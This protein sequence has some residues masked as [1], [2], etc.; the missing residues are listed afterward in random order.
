MGVTAVSRATSIRSVV[1]ALLATATPTGVAAAEKVRG[2]DPLVI[3]QSSITRGLEGSTRSSNRPAPTTLRHALSV[4]DPP[5]GPV[6]ETGRSFF[7]SR[8]GLV[9]LAVLGAGVGYAAYSKVHDRIHTK[10][11]GR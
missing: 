9:V 5:G 8:K 1:L 7:K 11:P 2:P 3:S 6:S 10:N 4:Q